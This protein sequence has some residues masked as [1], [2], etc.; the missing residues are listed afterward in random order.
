M[1]LEKLAEASHK[2][3]YLAMAKQ[4]WTFGGRWN[5]QTRHCPWLKPYAALHDSVKEAIR[6]QVRGTLQ[7]IEAGGGEIPTLAAMPSPPPAPRP[8]PTSFA[9]AAPAAAPSP[10]PVAAPVAPPPVAAP[11]R[12]AAQAVEGEKVERKVD[13]SGRMRVGS[14]IV[15][16]AELVNG[17]VNQ[18]AIVN[19]GDHLE[20]LPYDNDLPDAF[21]ASVNPDGFMLPKQMLSAFTAT[22]YVLTVLPGR[23]FVHPKA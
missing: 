5:D 7:A 16:K 21:Y 8:A 14:G 1:D 3:W 4:G 18:V 6:A 2:A 15:K 19:R 13:T 23:V 22:E 11:A 9:P 17:G 12:P 10:A 20:V